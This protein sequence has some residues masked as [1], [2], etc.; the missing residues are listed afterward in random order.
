MRRRNKRWEINSGGFYRWLWQDRSSLPPQYLPRSNLRLLRCATAW[1]GVR[2]AGRF[3]TM[4]AES[5]GGKQGF[6]LT[7]GALGPTARRP[8]QTGD[9]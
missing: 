1:T 7:P 9:S 3:G 5:I 4:D 8:A 6:M 2:T